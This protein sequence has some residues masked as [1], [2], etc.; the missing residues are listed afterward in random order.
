MTD[1]VDRASRRLPPGALQGRIQHGG[2]QEIRRGQG[3]QGGDVTMPDVFWL[4]LGFLA[5]GAVGWLLAWTLLRARAPQEE[6]AV[7]SGLRAQVE[8]LAQGQTTVQQ[9]L[10]TVQGTLGELQARLVATGADIKDHLARDVQEA[11][12]AIDEVR[13]AQATR[14][15]MEDELRQAVGRIEAVMAGRERR[16]EAGEQIVAAALRQLPASMVEQG[17]KVNGKVVEFA[18]VLPGGRRLPIDSKWTAGDLLQRLA[19]APRGPETDDLADEIERTVGRR[20]REVAQYISPPA[21][22]P[23]AVACVPDPAYAV[24]RKAHLEA[25]RVGVIV[26]PYSLTLP[27]LLTLYQMHLQY[28]GSVDVERLSTAL[29]QMERHLE[30]LERTLENSVARAITMLE[31]AYGDLKRGTGDLRGAL[32][33][34]RQPAREAREV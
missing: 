18:L 6:T 32:A 34:L 28:A 20:A 24:C 12:R 25:Y 14:R 26:L 27:Y 17:F 19:E 15:Q 22:L 11:R 9:A 3:I 31:N 1:A 23:W 2:L 33:G 30:A 7:L 8:V 10:T 5:A 16:G 4:L 21:T 29:T 13:T